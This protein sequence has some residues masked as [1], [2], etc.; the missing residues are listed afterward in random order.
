MTQIALSSNELSISYSE[1]DNHLKPKIKKLRQHGLT[2]HRVMIIG[3]KNYKTIDDYLWVLAVIENGGCVITVSKKCSQDE[4]N[5]KCII[6]NCTATIYQDKITL[7]LDPEHHTREKNEIFLCFTSGTSGK[8]SYEY[9]PYFLKNQGDFGTSVLD[10]ISLAQKIG[11]VQPL[12]QIVECGFEIPYNIDSFL[13]SYYSGG[14]FHFINDL[15]DVNNGIE[16]ANVNY[17]SGFPNSIKRIIDNTNYHVP[18]WEIGG[19]QNNKNLID[20]IFDRASAKSVCNLFASAKSGYTLYSVINH[21]DQFNELQKMMPTGFTQIKL[22]NN[23]LYFKPKSKQWDTDYDMFEIDNKKYIYN[24]RRSDTFFQTQQGVKINPYEIENYCKKINFVNNA[25]I[26]IEHNQ[27][28]L[29]LSTNKN[30]I[31]GERILTNH[32]SLLPEYKKPKKIYYVHDDLFATNIKVSRHILNLLI[33]KKP[34]ACYHTQL[35]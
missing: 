20:S 2:N 18:Y 24:G 25:Y 28:V 9:Y 22:K 3:N 7:N 1:L 23:Y 5:E 29:Y 35:L 34:D 10:C 15:K 32:L 26:A 33:K 17:I 12:N 13:K 31:D 21:K 14:R 6:T 11:C 4:I 19:G 30:S 27:P 16:I 8:K